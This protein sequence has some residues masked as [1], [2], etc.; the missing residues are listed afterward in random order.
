MLQ[1][2]LMHRAY[3]PAGHFLILYYQSRSVMSV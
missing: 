3:R 2:F 1:R